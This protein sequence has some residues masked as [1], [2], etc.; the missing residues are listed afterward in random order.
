[1]YSGEIIKRMNREKTEEAENEG[2]TP[3]V[4]TKNGDEGIRRATRLGDFLPQG[5]EEV[6]EF[7]V[8]SSGFG[9]EGEGA[10]TFEQFLTKVRK[11]YGYGIGE[12]GQFQVYIKEYKRI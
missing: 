5:W 7:F 3:Y 10:L 6:N 4:A 2:L 11:G 12:C 1:M 9:R 8:D